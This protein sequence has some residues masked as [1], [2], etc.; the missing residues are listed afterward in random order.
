MRVFAVLLALTLVACKDGGE[1][2]GG[3]QPTAAPAAPSNKYACK[4]FLARK[5]TVE[6]VTASV[7]GDDQ[8]AA[9]A[10]AR[11]E[12][13]DKLPEAH[14]GECGDSER[15]SASVVNGSMTANGQT[16][17]TVK[18]Q[19]SQVQQRVTGKGESTESM[20]Q[21]CADALAAGCKAGGAEGD[22]VAAGTFEK[23]GESTERMGFN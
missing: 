13:C 8:A 15:W 3:N 6:P 5:A 7:S 9:E 18:V 1:S 11:K 14:R 16:T 2:S 10:Q 23:Q 20:D 17:H 22:C 21:A 19:L 12:A 4:V